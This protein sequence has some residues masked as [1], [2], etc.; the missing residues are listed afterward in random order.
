METAGWHKDSKLPQQGGN[1]VLSGF[2]NIQGEVFRYIVDLKPGDVLT[3]YMGNQPYRYKVVDR[4]ILKDKGEPPE[5]RQQNAR[6][7]GQVNEERVA[8]I[9]AGGR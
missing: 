4:L 6:W 3:L 7:I 5:V 1:I 2:H 9:S 8:E